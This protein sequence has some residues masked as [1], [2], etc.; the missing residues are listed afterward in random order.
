MWRVFESM[1]INLRI[2]YVEGISRL[3]ERLQLTDKDTATW[4]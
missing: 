4:R 2:P 1:I 3:S